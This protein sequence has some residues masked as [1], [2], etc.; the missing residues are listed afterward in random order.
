VV[1]WADSI[2]QGRDVAEVRSSSSATDET[3][4]LATLGAFVTKS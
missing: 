2:V 3:M 4:R 1:S